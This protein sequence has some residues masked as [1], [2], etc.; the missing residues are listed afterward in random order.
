M[1]EVQNED[2]L[3]FSFTL[4][5]F[6]LSLQ[7]DTRTVRLLSSYEIAYSPFPGLRGFRTSEFQ[8]FFGRANQVQQ[9]LDRLN[10]K[11][12]LTVIGSSGS[13]KSSLV[14]AGLIPQLFGGYL[15]TKRSHWNIAICRPGRSPIHN[16]AVALANVKNSSKDRSLLLK[17]YE[18]IR[19]TITN[20]SY[21]LLEVNDF[22]NEDKPV[23]KQ[24]NLLVVIDQFE[25]LFRFQQGSSSWESIEKN[26]IDLL[27]KATSSSD[28]SVYVIIIMRAE[29]LGEC[30]SYRGLPDAINGNQY[31]V[32]K[33]NRSELKE[34]IESPIILAGKTISTSLVELLINQIDLNN[35]DRSLDQLPILQHAL[36]RTYQAASRNDDREIT[37]EHY[38]NIGE[39]EN[40]L[41]LH[42]NEIFESL[43]DNNISSQHSKKQ[44]IAKIIFQALTDFSS[45]FKG[46]RRPTD[47]KTIY[48][49]A[50]AIGATKEEVNEVVNHFRNT[51]TLFITPFIDTPLQDELII[52]ISHESLMR[53]WHL[54]KLWAEEETRS[55]KIYQRLNELREDRDIQMK[56]VLLK[57][58]Q[59]WRTTYPHNAAW[60]S[61]Y[62]RITN[63]SNPSLHN[64][65]YSENL[66]FLEL[67]LKRQQR[68]KRLKLVL[69]GLAV[70]IFLFIIYIFIEYEA[71]KRNIQ[72]AKDQEELVNKKIQKA[73]AKVDTILMLFHKLQ[74][75]TIA[76]QDSSFS[77]IKQRERVV[78]LTDSLFERAKSLK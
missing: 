49:I 23:D 64:D 66:S 48:A 57:E 34:V 68:D 5:D 15:Y 60:A 16:L 19:S 71:A 46:G 62:H 38:E 45:E 36:M 1:V 43:K 67:N 63:E 12:F 37:Y 4:D 72:R 70:I 26:F 6:Y 18:L 78:K 40:A 69:S 31:L 24:A 7:E 8:L 9:L 20:S 50:S 51:E 61:R 52:D 11:R 10:Q 75:Q 21:G 58:M 2:D 14:L 59:L 22:L 17:D 28:K 42:A 47:L 55:G 32:P 41:S 30:V 3:Q 65:I 29:F 73:N 44:E 77:T 33:L 74:E 35:Y 27:L 54:L 53:N 76:I 25:E 13:G 56:G 39:M